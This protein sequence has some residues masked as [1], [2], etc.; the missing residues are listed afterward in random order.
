MTPTRAITRRHCLQQAFGIGVG[1]LLAS[2]GLAADAKPRRILLCSGWQWISIADIS[3]TPGSIRLLQSH[4]RDAEI[5]LWLYKTTDPIRDMIR[6]AFPR[7]K[8]VEGTIDK[9]TLQITGDDL[10]KALETTDL[11]IH[12]SAPNLIAPE[13]LTWCQTNKKPFGVLGIGLGDVDEKQAVLLSNT[14]FAFA[15]DSSTLNA[16]KKAGVKGPTLGAIPDSAFAFNLRDETAG[17]VFLK[18]VGLTDGQ[19]FC[20]VPRLRFTPFRRFP[21]DVLRQ[22]AATNEQFV[23]VDHGKLRDAITLAVRKTGMKVLACPEMSYE[24]DLID[25]HIIN[26]LPDDVKKNVVKRGTFWLPDEAASVFARA[27]AVVSFE[28]HAAILALTAGVPAIYLHQP[29]EIHKAQIF[30]DI[31]LTPW[32]QEIDDSNGDRIAKPLLEVLTNAEGARKRVKKAMSVVDSLYDES[33]ATIVEL[34]K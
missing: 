21:A 17:T 9:Q 34:L 13:L 33:F 31:G 2:A 6:R 30:R 12:G 27:A 10:R 14:K 28:T 3:Q 32:V 26:P 29:N 24:I 20:I 4:L 5:T 7:L 18:S 8:I 25:K 19:F 15:R 23:E 22:R 11:A 16:I 1:G